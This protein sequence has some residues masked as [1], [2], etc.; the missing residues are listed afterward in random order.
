MFNDVSKGL[1]PAFSLLFPPFTSLFSLFSNIISLF[2]FDL[3]F[4]LNSS[5]HYF[6]SN[7][8]F[9][10]S[11]IYFFLFFSLPLSTSFLLPLS[12]PLLNSSWRREEQVSPKPNAY[13]LDAMRH[14]ADCT[15]WMPPWKSKSLLTQL[16]HLQTTK[17]LSFH[18]KKRKQ[19]QV[20]KA[21]YKHTCVL[22]ILQQLS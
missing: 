7:S 21:V 16:Y 18:W 5:L 4:F 10:P 12:L 22:G 3:T 17:A 19:N 15:E 9:L 11:F 14:R 8:I 2:P 1:S 6:L 13:N 20:D